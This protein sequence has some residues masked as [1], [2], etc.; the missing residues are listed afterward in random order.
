MIVK[1]ISINNNFLLDVLINE[2]N[3]D[4]R[5]KRTIQADKV[6]IS[7]TTWIIYN[8]TITQNNVTSKN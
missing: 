1:S 7:N 2:F 4:F 6:D 8:P 3:S 5:L